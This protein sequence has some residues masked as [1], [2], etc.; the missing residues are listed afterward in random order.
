MPRAVGVAGILTD[1]VCVGGAVLPHTYGRWRGVLQGASAP[2]A[3]GAVRLLTTHGAT[4]TRL[5]TTHGATP[6]R[7][8]FIALH[9]WYLGTGVFYM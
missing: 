8:I 5:L 4:P 1:T 2:W 9:S 7:R 6:T 3:V